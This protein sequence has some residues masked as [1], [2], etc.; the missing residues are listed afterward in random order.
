MRRALVTVMVSLVVFASAAYAQRITAAIRGTVRDATQAVVPGATVTLRGELSGL[1][2]TTTT[3]EEGAYVFSDLPVGTGTFR[4]DVSL[5][6]FKSA[7]RSN[8][9]LNV[10]D[11]RE[12]NFEIAAGDVSEVVTVEAA[13]VAVQ[14]IGGDVSGVITGEQARELP[15][16]GRNFMQLTMLMPGVT[17]N[18]GLNTKAKGL[19]GGSDVSVSGSSTTSNVWMVDGANNNDVG[20]NRTILVYPSVDAIE[21]FKIQ[22]NNYGAEFGQAGGAQVNVITRGGTNEFHGSGYYYARRD[23]MN[24]IDYFLEQAGQEKA[25]LKFDDFG[26]TIGGPIIKD[27]LH[28]FF[29]EELNKD[30]RTSIRNGF[31]PTLA[32]RAGNF[33]LA[34]LAGCTQS[35][36]VDPLT[37]Q[38]FPGGVIP[39]DRLSPGG[40]ALLQLY[41]APNT[42]PDA[43]CNNWQQAVDTPVEW[44][45]ENI[46][47]DWSMTD[48]TRL[49]VRYT[50]DKWQ[51]DNTNLWGDDPF[52]VVGSTWDQPGKSLVV[53][54]NKNIGSTAVNSLTFSYSMNKINV[55]R[56]GEDPGV[57]DDINRLIPT[58]YNSD[59]KQQGGQAQPFLGWGGAAG[60]YSVLWNQ[61]P[62]VNNQ[63]LFVLKDDYSKVFGKHFVRVGGLASW[64]KKNEEPNNT[65][66]E[67]V[68]FDTAVGYLGPNGFMP[69][70]TTGNTV[71]DLLLRGMVFQTAEVQAN[72]PVQQ[73]WN[74]F[75]FYIADSYKASPRLTVDLGVRFS[76]L[77]FPYEAEDRMASFNPD[78]VDPNVESPC[79]GL[80]FP[81]GENPCP[82]LDLAG[83]A[84]GPNRS[85]RPTKA[86]LIAPRVG[87]A[88]DVNG[89]GR[90]AL[91]GGV[92]LFY[93]RE[94][95][96]PGL[97]SGLN[98]PFSGTTSLARTIDSAAPATGGS[99]AVGF[100]TAGMGFEQRAANPHNWQWNLTVEREL[101]RNTK[102]ELSYVGNKGSDLTGNINLNEV[103]PHLRAQFARTNDASLRPYDEQLGNG[104]LA[105]WQHNRSSIYHALQA[106]LLS[107]FGNGSQVTLSYTWSRAIANEPMNSA[108]SGLSDN[109]TASDSTNLDLDRGRG[110]IDRTH[111]FAGTALWVLPSFEDKGAAFRH[112]LGDWQVTGIVAAS[113]G[114]PITIFSGGVSG[115]PGGLSGTGYSGNH[116]P[117]R[118][119]GVDCQAQSSSDPEQWLN[120]AAWTLNGFRI[121]E[122]GDSGRGICEGPGY[123]SVDMGLFK[124]IKVGKRVTLQLRGEMFNVFNRVNFLANPQ[125]GQVLNRTYNAENV[126]LGPDTVVSATP[127][128]NFGRLNQAGD[129]RQ[130]QLG[131]KLIF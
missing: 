33:S 28:F 44:R 113:T 98:P 114:Y 128:G 101:I 90:T 92:G 126:V 106:Q 88:W 3:N 16:N 85:L 102:L 22:R 37:G 27:K 21:E 51:A 5:A 59:I 52:P 57:I 15:L 104:N 31:V 35:A 120:P 32:E 40:Q 70:V 73:R 100:P 124:N 94:R 86:L 30:N 119:V 62:W 4:V 36:P 127:A 6:G 43:G 112:I 66:Q 48:S 99:A 7:A 58:L 130:V 87:F 93:N 54:L 125:G 77:R 23:S 63:D 67:S 97:I 64:N 110:L 1:S 111:V 34:P 108:D 107:R 50:Q 71:G 61:A 75:E 69:G 46:R 83:G 116:R 68:L 78:E 121:G 82:A 79:N 122:I 117:N 12:V 129:A 17:A 131:L 123:F 55:T 109:L 89:D 72:T 84:D 2:R 45:Q 76:H 11:V 19:E 65:S 38:P 60:P 105:F 53:Q 9:L 14:T 20:S 26:A 18:E 41:S 29:S 13:A 103:P 42:N 25:P 80:L 10:A 74:D 47:V 24:S 81:P 49:M 118:V 39:A 96:S 8:I 91:R 115:L 95:L 56:G